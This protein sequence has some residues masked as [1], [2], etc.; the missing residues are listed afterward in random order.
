MILETCAARIAIFYRIFVLLL[1][2]FD[3]FV[4]GADIF[5]NSIVNTQNIVDKY[6]KRVL[7]PLNNVTGA[8]DRNLS[9]VSFTGIF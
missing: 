4:C 8:V 6:S 1:I 3:K 2:I 5:K 7:G 9:P